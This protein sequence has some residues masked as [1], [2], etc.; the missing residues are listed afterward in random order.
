M[1]ISALKF[2]LL[3]FLFQ[4]LLFAKDVNINNILK[5]AQLSHKKVFLFLHRTGCSYCNSMIE[6]TLD[7]ERVKERLNKS[8]TLISINITDEDHIFYQ[9]FDGKAHDFAKYIGYDIYPTSLFLAQ[10]GDIDFVKIG[11][12][13]ESEFLIILNYVQ[14]K[15]FTKISYDAYKKHYIKSH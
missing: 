12:K 3:F 1:L 8:F 6:F 9:A 2:I 4:N 15:D 10:N 5:T 13:E 7:D 11:Y 14:S